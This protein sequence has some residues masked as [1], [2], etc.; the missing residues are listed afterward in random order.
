MINTKIIK[1]FLGQVIFSTPY[2]DLHLYMGLCLQMEVHSES[3]Q[4][5]IK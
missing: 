5:K 2:K 1:T 3:M 4:W